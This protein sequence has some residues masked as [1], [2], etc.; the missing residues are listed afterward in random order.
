MSKFMA[1]MWLPVF[2]AATG[3]CLCGCAS[4]QEDV[5]GV[6]KASKVKVT[7]IKSDDG[8]QTILAATA[9]GDNGLFF[10]RPPYDLN[11]VWRAEATCGIYDVRALGA[12][13][14]VI[15]G[16]ESDLR[17]PTATPTEFYG[18]YGR[19]FETP[20]AGLQVFA[21]SHGGNHGQ[22][23]FSGATKVDLALESDGENVTFLARDTGLGG[24]YTTVATVAVTSPGDS[25]QAGF[26]MFGATKGASIGFTNFRVPTNGAP[27]TPPPAAQQA[28]NACYEAAM[29][30]LE[31][32]YAV[33]GPTVN[34]DDADTADA[35]LADAQNDLVTARVLITEMDAGENA[36]GAVAAVDSA[37]KEIAKVR[38]AID[39][40]GAKGASKL[41]KSVAKKLF[42]AALTVTDELITDELRDALPGEG[43]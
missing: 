23:F 4:V 36:G 15:F 39:R 8:R 37:T 38:K 28:M 3:L 35:F 25:H 42:K 12:A 33:D 6:A 9:R 13:L 29:L 11:G 30:V 10:A 2:V 16:L 20:T 32:V 1:R 27:V 7:Q 26:G 5:K 43:I 22:T 14:G 41:T 40:K 18:V 21:A 34:D 19:Y 24:S 31:A 17:G